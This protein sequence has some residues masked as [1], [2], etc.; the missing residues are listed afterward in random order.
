MNG[1]P[2]IAILLSQP[3][4]LLLFFTAELPSVPPPH[5]QIPRFPSWTAELNLRSFARALVAYLPRTSILVTSGQVLVGVLKGRVC[6][7][8]QIL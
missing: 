8:H 6:F 2:F 3:P 7:L 4:K 1:G 5:L